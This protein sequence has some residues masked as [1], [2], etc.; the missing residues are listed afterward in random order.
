MWKGFKENRTVRTGKRG[1]YK[2]KG[3]GT[4][5]KEDIVDL[6]ADDDEDVPEGYFELENGGILR[7][8]F[9]EIYNFYKRRLM[10]PEE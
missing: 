6:V 3:S 4:R 1:T 10:V 2:N 9:A 5:N 7:N 8:E